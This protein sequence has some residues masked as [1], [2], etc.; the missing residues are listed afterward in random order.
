MRADD[1]LLTSRGQR[2]PEPLRVVLSRSLDL[3]DQAQLWDQTVATTLVAHGLIEAVCSEDDSA[4]QDQQ[5]GSVLERLQ[6]HGVDVQQL[7]RCEPDSL[8]KHLGSLGCNQVLWECGP[9][10]AAVALRQGCVQELAVVIAPKLMGGSLA[11]T[12]LGDLGFTAMDQVL[13][14]TLAAAQ[15]LGPDLLLQAQL[16]PE[17]I[18]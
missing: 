9:S 12:P 5:R 17:R 3:P 11:C 6:Q 1:P 13:P 14:L 8:M 18:G 10:L 7:V 16:M 15:Q 4:K 2:H